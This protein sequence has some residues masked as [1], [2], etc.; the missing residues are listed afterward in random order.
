MVMNDEMLS[1]IKNMKVVKSNKE[2]VEDNTKTEY[3][4]PVSWGEP[5]NNTPTVTVIEEGSKIKIT[6]KA[7]KQP[8]V[9]QESVKQEN[10]IL[11][12]DLETT[13]NVTT[14]KPYKLT[15]EYVV[16]KL[17]EYESEEIYKRT[18]YQKKTV[19]AYDLVGCI[20]KV[21]YAIK[22][23][24]ERPA[25]NSYPYG[26]LVTSMGNAVHDIL[27]KRLPSDSNEL[28]IKISDA[29]DIVINVRSDILWNPEVVVE[30]KTKDI[31]PK[32]A[33]PEHVVQAM[34]YAYLLNKYHNYNIQ[35]VQVLYVARGK[36]DISI[37]DVPITPDYMLKVGNK[38]EKFTSSLMTYVDKDVP[39]PMD[40]QYVTTKACV[41]CNY[42]HECQKHQAFQ[43]L[44]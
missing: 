23:V 33:E 42:K 11:I 44:I 43:S 8:I 6:P 19:N 15:K 26:E 5:V 25:P 34:I 14:D 10:Q 3:V 9:K 20:R 12:P 32:T 17:K 41:F 40:H 1:Y 31:A 4:G 38:I 39:P 13:I 7:T 35:L 24:E 22:G 21:Y 29:Y 27:Q 2:I 37:I 30:I 36:V 16:S 28:K 18:T